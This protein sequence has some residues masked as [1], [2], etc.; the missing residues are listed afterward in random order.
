MDKFCFSLFVGL[1]FSYNMYIQVPSIVPT[2]T[3]KA[4]NKYLLNFKQL[5]I[6]LLLIIIEC[7]LLVDF[8]TYPLI[9]KIILKEGVIISTIEI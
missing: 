4:L 2:N 5:F 3:Y 7:Y 1:F 9:L 8:Y 6:K